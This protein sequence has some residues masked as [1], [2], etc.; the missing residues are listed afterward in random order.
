MS[1]YSHPVGYVLTYL[2]VGLFTGIIW[3]GVGWMVGQ[4]G[5]LLPTF[6][7][8]GRFDEKE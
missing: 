8:V 6:L 2:A 5:G 1:T 7:D 3:Q 4:A